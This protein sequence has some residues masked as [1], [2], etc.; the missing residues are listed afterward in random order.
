MEVID[1]FV[2][3][4][5]VNPTRMLM[6]QLCDIG[7]IEPFNTE[8]GVTYFNDCNGRYGYVIKINITCK[9]ESYVTSMCIH[10][11][12]SNDI[13]NV[14]Y[15][16][17][18]IIYNGKFVRPEDYYTFFDIINDVLYGNSVNLVGEDGFVYIIKK[19]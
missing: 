18:D 8:N 11:R 19:I 7:Y 5:N 12:L 2:Q 1:T 14:V 4:Y 3:D 6:P 15:Y 13:H 16:G 10:N 17:P 9:N